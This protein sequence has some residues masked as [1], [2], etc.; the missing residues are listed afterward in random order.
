MPADS[1]TLLSQQTVTLTGSVRDNLNG[2]LSGATITNLSTGKSTMSSGSGTFSI[3]AAKRDT[4]VASYIGY[5]DFI[6]QHTDRLNYDVVLTP[7][8]GSLND[9]VV[10]GFGR[11]QTQSSVVG[12]ISSV[13]VAQLQHPVA[14]LN[15]MLAG[16]IAGII[17]VQRSGLPGSNSADIWIRG[18]QTFG[19]NPS[20]PLVIIDGVQGRD[21][22]NYDPEDIQ[23]FSILKDASA[24]AMYGSQGAN[25]VILI[26]TKRGSPGKSQIMA[27]YIE[28]FTNFTKMPKM[29]DAGTYMRLKNEAQIA[30]GIAPSY[31]QAYIDSTESVT[32]DHFVYPNVDWFNQVLKKNARFRKANVSS[33]GGTENTQYYVA[34]TYYNESSMIKTD[35]DQKLYDAN[36]LFQRYNFTS[37]VDMKWTKTTRFSLSIGGYISEFNEP[38]AGAG[39]AFSNSMNASPVLAPAFYPGNLRAGVARGNS[40]SPNPWADVAMS[41]YSNTY[42]SQINS[43]A[44]LQQDLGF[45]VKGLSANA[46]YSF[47][48]KNTSTSGRRLNRSVWYVNQVTPYNPDGSLNFGPP[49]ITGS[50]DLVFSQ[51][52]SGNRQNT[53]QATLSYNRTFGDHNVTGMLVY[54][55]RSTMDPFDGDLLD[56]IP[57]RQQNYA[58][59]A[60]YTYKGKYLFEFNLGYNGSEDYVPSKRFGWFPAPGIGWIVSKEAFFE[61]L[62]K[63][64]QYFKLR[65]SNGLSGAPGTGKRFGYATLV[66]TGANGYTFGSGSG[67]QGYNGVNILQYGADVTWAV[68]HTQ[69]WGW[70]FHTLNGQLQFVL[71]YWYSYRTKVF[72]DRGDF[73]AFAGLQYQPVGNVGIVKASGFDAQVTLTPFT[74]GRNMTLGFNGTATYSINS[75][76]KNASPPVADPYQSPIGQY[77]NRIM[78][79]VAEKLFQSE[80]EI[81]NSPDQR[82]LGGNP[83]PGD[84]KYK[85]LN[86]DGTIN[87]YDQ[88]VI[89]N[90]DVPKWIFGAG[91]NYTLGNFYVSAFFQGNLGSYRTISGN[92][93]SPFSG[94]SLGAD[95][96]NV[97]A[98]VTDR[99]TPENP[100]ERPFYPR[101]GFGGPA[102]N[103]N[104]V[105]STWWVRDISFV[106]LKTANVGYNFKNHKW[107]NHMSMKNLQ[108]YLDG[109]NLWYWSPFKLWDPELNTGNGNSYP[110]V[111]QLSIGIRANF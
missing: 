64:F 15:T 9:V 75:L 55:Q 101:L 78:G 24:T 84:I 59:K 71:D 60:A 90:G 108:V 38:G 79:Y 87:Q 76:Q 83:R 106:R 46:Q 42:N 102:N 37:N 56:Y 16:R 99:W 107:M 100:V 81:A 69:D 70:D 43:T 45:W 47:D 94:S 65:Y 98:M 19:N 97:F 58:G 66:T 50:D 6:W 91:F 88:T 53:F 12:A 109:I 103:N 28:G 10:T 110:N 36:T 8:V 27:Q 104:A 14:N 111:R 52:N 62:S 22:N 1:S 96:G 67:S 95:D 68:A 4:L 23:S 5:Q 34:L 57:R 72:L 73:P 93:R 29:A 74:I 49:Q 3:D 11:R 92:A 82:P 77:T 17:G 35:P 48:N 7:V 31:S 2:I 39:S 63:V 13:D 32:A 25:G 54:F 26:T 86:G 44:V 18:I 21:I 20:G 51:G 89:S 80:A 105:A 41:G 33:T 85:D 30:S 40:S 61:P